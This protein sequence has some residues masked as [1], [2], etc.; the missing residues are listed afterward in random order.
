MEKALKL[1]G[2]LKANLVSDEEL[3][4]AAWKAAVGPR[5]EAHARFRAYFPGRIV[6]EVDDR[7]WQNQLETLGPSIVKKMEGLTGRELRALIEFHLAIAR[8]APAVEEVPFRLS[9]PAS[10]ESRIQDP[11]LRRIY[12]NSK[13]RAKAV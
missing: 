3:L 10:E 13:R 7:I 6:I 11:I 12:A 9:A 2:K 5:I 1:I 4:R 8:P